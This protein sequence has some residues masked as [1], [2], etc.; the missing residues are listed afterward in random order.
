MSMRYLS[1]SCPSRARCLCAA[2]LRG[3]STLSCSWF[4]SLCVYYFL[5][6]KNHGAVGLLLLTVG[7]AAT[8]SNEEFFKHSVSLL[9][10]HLQLRLCLE[11]PSSSA[12]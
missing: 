10:K 2:A 4:C 5:P 12:A 3:S 6:Y 9:A 7:T 1:I 11:K 8:A